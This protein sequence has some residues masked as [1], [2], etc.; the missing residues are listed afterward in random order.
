MKNLLRK[1]VLTVCIVFGFAAISHSQITKSDV[2]SMLVQQGITM[3]AVKNVYVY[4]V[5]SFYQDGSSKYVYEDYENLKVSISSTGILI[6]G[7][8]VQLFPFSSM[9]HLTVGKTSMTIHLM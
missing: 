8:A 7:T 2:E 6:Q 4:N 1:F 3:A 5:K 9:R